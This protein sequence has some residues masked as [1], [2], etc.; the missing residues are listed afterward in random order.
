MK[1]ATLPRT[2]MLLTLAIPAGLVL[3]L[4]ATVF[5]PMFNAGPDFAAALLGG[6]TI[7]SFG[8]LAWMARRRSDRTVRRPR[9]LPVATAIARPARPIFVRARVVSRDREQLAA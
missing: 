4:L 3:A 5:L 6:L 2:T 8:A 9:P 1:T 7:Y